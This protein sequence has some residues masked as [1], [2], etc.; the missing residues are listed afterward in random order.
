MIFKDEEFAK[1]VIRRYRQLRRS[2]LS[3]KYLSDY[4]DDT[5]E[6]LGP[7]VERNYQRW[8]SAFDEN[9]L[10]VQIGETSIDRNQHTPE[11]AVDFLKDWIVDRGDWLDEK[12]DVLNFFGHPSY[13]KR[14]NH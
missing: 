1:R 10:T 7:A 5:M 14:W 3:D 12:I 9:M 6:W 13:N 4:I 2:I 11:E 8:K